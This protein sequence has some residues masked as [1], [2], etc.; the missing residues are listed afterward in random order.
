MAETTT[1]AATTDD[2]TTATETTDL[3]AAANL[4]DSVGL[5]IVAEPVRESTTEVTNPP[6]T[7]CEE[8]LCC[9]LAYRTLADGD[10]SGKPKG[11]LVV[12]QVCNT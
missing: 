5:E 12:L 9:G 8:N 4:K 1:S 11:T 2:T 6:P 3:T 10:S 7:P